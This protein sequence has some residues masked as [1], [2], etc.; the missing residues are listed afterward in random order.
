MA[1]QPAGAW[2]W[3]RRVQVISAAAAGAGSLEAWEPEATQGN[4]RSSAS[5]GGS[6]RG[7]VRLGAGQGPS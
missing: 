1:N 5:G 6:A 7:R 3:Q 4:Q 2:I